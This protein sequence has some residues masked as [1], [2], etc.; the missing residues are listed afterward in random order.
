MYAAAI[1]AA[2]A[3]SSMAIAAQS[4]A[5]AQQPRQETMFD[6]LRVEVTRRPDMARQVQASASLQLPGGRVL[7]AHML[8]DQDHIEQAEIRVAQM[9]SERLA[10]M[11]ARE[12]MQLQN[13]EPENPNYRGHIE[14]NVRE[15]LFFNITSQ[16]LRQQGHERHAHE[17]R[18]RADEIRRRHAIRAA[19][20]QVNP[21]IFIDRA[22][23]ID[24]RPGAVNFGRSPA[25][26]AMRY[27]ALL[28]AQM[29]QASEVPQEIREA[30]S[31]GDIRFN[32]Q[33]G[34]T[35]MRSPW[36]F[37]ETEARPA[38]SKLKQYKPAKFKLSQ[39]PIIKEVMPGLM[40]IPKEDIN[41]RVLQIMGEKK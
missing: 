27:A 22:E 20:M 9:V 12:F 24:M 25:A 40:Q 16:M 36:D 11:L 26:D 39:A 10:S 32:M 4:A 14:S 18:M 23:E 1:A 17:M 38:K 15:Q 31:N 35:R 6:R 37:T 28:N 29:A 5:N 3:A 34:S 8:V 7:Q 41:E 30:I 13:V 33:L 19:Q 2:T 21:P